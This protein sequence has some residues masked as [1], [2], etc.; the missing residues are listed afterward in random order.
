MNLIFDDGD[1]DE[2]VQAE[3]FV[4]VADEKI[5]VGVAADSGASDNVIG[6]DDLP[7]GV[8]PMGPSGKPFSN[9][10]GGDI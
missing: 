3:G 4:A 7:A 10:S 8:E 1:G 9:A 6:L 5:R 2:Y